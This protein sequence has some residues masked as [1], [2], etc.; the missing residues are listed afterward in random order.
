MSKYTIY[1]DHR[2]YMYR[3][4]ARAWNEW[5]DGSEL[6]DYQ[7]K[8]MKLFFRQIGKRFGLI[9]EFKELGVI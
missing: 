2:Q 4:L 6:P 1:Y 7:V 5:A 3:D 8:G 9:T